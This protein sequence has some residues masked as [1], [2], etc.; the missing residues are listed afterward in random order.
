MYLTKLNN[1]D[2]HILIL[3]VKYFLWQHIVKLLMCVKADSLAHSTVSIALC[4]V[5]T[6]YLDRNWPKSERVVVLYTILETFEGLETV[7]G[8]I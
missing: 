8:Y 2:Q 5:I 6:T 1:L 3:A 7:V 4:W